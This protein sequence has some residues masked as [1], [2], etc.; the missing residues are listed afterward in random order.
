M[1][2]VAKRRSITWT[3]LGWTIVQKSGF[4]MLFPILISGFCV[5]NSRK[6]RT[7][8]RRGR[9]SRIAAQRAR[10]ERRVSLKCHCYFS[11]FNVVQ[12]SHL[13]IYINQHWREKRSFCIYFWSHFQFQLAFLTN[14]SELPSHQRHS[15]HIPH[16]SLREVERDHAHH[17][18]VELGRLKIQVLLSIR[19]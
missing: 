15:R 7:C 17:I 4:R 16:E 10:G 18:G 14:P 3:E 13:W 1:N 5:V 12:D 19:F 6:R 8:M 11:I 2:S 9:S